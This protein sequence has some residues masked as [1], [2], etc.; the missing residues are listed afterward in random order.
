MAKKSTDFDY[1]NPPDELDNYDDYEDQ[2]EDKPSPKKSLSARRRL[3]EL[4]E[5]R[6]LSR[7]LKDDLYDYDW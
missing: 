3:D 2:Y 5:E 6:C 1:S 7:L 4:M